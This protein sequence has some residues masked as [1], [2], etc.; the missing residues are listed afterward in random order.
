MTQTLDRLLLLNDAQLELVIFYMGVNTAFLPQ[1]TRA[2]RSIA[3]LRLAKQKPE[4]MQTLET[5][6]SEMLGAPGASPAASPSTSAPQ[7]GGNHTTINIGTMNVSDG[8]I[9]IKQGD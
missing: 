5:R 1:G 2:E 9:G 4:M 3:L 8:G 7:T 6:L